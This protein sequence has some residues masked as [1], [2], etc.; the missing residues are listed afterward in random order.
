MCSSIFRTH[1]ATLRSEGHACDAWEMQACIEF[2]VAHWLVDL[3]FTTRTDTP[4]DV[5]KVKPNILKTACARI[6]RSALHLEH[7][8][9]RAQKTHICIFRHSICIFQN[10]TAPTSQL[11][12]N[13]F[14]LSDIPFVLFNMPRHPRHS[15]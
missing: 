2:E 8:L 11:L 15:G 5:Q 9:N 4:S 1:L 3:N 13:T 6:L 14:V 12:K 10:A 7:H